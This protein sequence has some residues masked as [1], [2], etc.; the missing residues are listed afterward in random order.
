[1]NFLLS[2][3]QKTRSD[4]YCP[5]ITMNMIFMLTKSSKTNESDKFVLKLSQKLNLRYPN[6]RVAL[7]NLEK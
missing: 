5:N 6:Q 4:N 3:Q 1:M 2:T 7:Q